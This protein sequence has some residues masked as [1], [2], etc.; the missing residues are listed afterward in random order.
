V[1][2]LAIKNLRANLT[3]LVATALAVLAGTAFVASG[4]VITEAI[5]NAVAG[6][7]EVQY[8]AVDAAVLP[9]PTLTTEGGIPADLL[10]TVAALP[11]VAAVAGEMAEPTQVLDDDGDPVRSQTLGRA[12][13][14]D[15]VLNPFTVAE[16]APPESAD[17]V[18]VDRETAAQAG[19]SVGDEV[20]L[21]TPAGPLT[22]TVSG[23]TE[24]GRS[25]SVDGGGTV[26]FSPE[27][28]LDVLS[29][30]AGQY[31][32]LLA[33]GDVPADDLVA[34]IG[35]VVPPSL[36]VDTGTQ[37]RDDAVADTE[38]LIA[39]LRPVLLGFAFL[40]LFVAAFVIYNTFSVVVAQRT[41]ELAL[42]R[43]VGGTPA[44]VRRSLLGEGLVLGVVVS[45]AGLAVGTLLAL[46]LQ[47][48]LRRVDL[49]IPSAGL[50]LTP[51]IVVTTVV[52]GTVATVAA[53]LIPAVRAGRT[54]PVEAM[55][56][57]ETDRSG[58][59]R[60]RLVIGGIMLVLAVALLVLNRF[61]FDKGA[62]VGLGSLLLFLGV[63]VGGPL[64]ARLFG[65]GLRRG[66]RPWLTGRLAADNLARNPKRTATTANALVIGL[67]LVTV[68]T[69]AGTAFKDWSL[70][71]LSKLS[72][73]DFIVAGTTPI[74]ADVV[75]GVAGVDGV[76]ATAPVRTAAVSDT[77]GN[78]AVLAGA[79]VAELEATTGL[80]ATEGSLDDVAAGRG[81]ATTTLEALIGASGEGGPDDGVS[82]GSATTEAGP[83]GA[84]APPGSGSP[85]DAEVEVG[86]VYVLYDTEGAPVEVPVVALVELKL[87]TLFLG[88]VVD[89]DL[90]TRIAG[91]QPVSSIYVRAEPGRVDEVGTGLDA[92]VEGYTGV[93][94]APGN[95]VG[96]ILGSLIDFLIAAVNGLLA[97]SVLIALIGIVNTMNLSIH[98]RRRELGMVR[99]LGMTA[100]QVR[101]MVRTEAVMIGVLGTITGTVA[102]VFLGWIVVGTL[103]DA[104]V[105]IPWGR[106]GII[107][108]IGVVISVLASLLPARSAVKA[109]MLEAIAAT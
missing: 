90:F 88:T 87:D 12:W 14:P 60:A 76:E 75:E 81:A 34:T 19:L 70:A 15:D 59:S 85:L 100:G 11:G 109:P 38:A 83:D 18:A 41:R 68:V 27:R 96:Q 16:G 21:A 71:E 55:R 6:N 8:G 93:V 40:A 66:L 5:G 43:A 47:W 64:V 3:R 30:G 42:V 58:T 108:G 99:A 31:R 92:V 36:V 78:I 74:P 79:D 25:A 105:E 23:I 106:V 52:A 26:F 46:L 82:P 48:V 17:E 53:V 32:Y 73:S 57:A 95:F 69:V 2:R 54:K 102:A 91:E 44:Q 94:V 28:G 20:A 35:T 1:L 24:F 101:S 86:S 89:E 84:G 63:V 97:L 104:S 98:E 65:L 7:V 51:G 77:S 62:L 10:D 22:A 56:S 67:F 13:I 29:P 37:F 107:F 72:S 49:P 80:T 61:V 103:T 50:A 39:F 33:R 9:D 45:V 4:L